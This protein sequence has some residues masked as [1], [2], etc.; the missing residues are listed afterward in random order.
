MTVLEKFYPE[1]RKQDGNYYTTA[2]LTAI[3]FSLQRFF[4]NQ[5]IGIIKGPE[6]RESNATFQATLVKLKREGM[7]KTQHKPPINKD[8]NKLYQSGLFDSNSPDTLQNRVFF[9]VMLYFCRRGRQNLR[10]LK[11]D[12]S[13]KTDPSKRKY[14]CKVKDELTKNRRETDEAQ[15]T[16]DMF[17]TGGLLCPV[18]SFEQYVSHLNPKNEFFFQRLKRLKD[19]S[20]D[21]WY[22]NMVVGQGT[23]GE[24]MKKLST[25]AE[26]SYIYTNHSIRATAIT[27]LDECG[28]EAR[29]IMAVSGHKSENSIRSYA[30][31]TSLSKKRKM[32]EAL[33]FSTS[34]NKII[35]DSQS[36]S[37][38]ES[39]KSLATTL[40][41][42]RK[43]VDTDRFPRTLF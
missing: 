24:K 36:F 7:A 26:L 35:S 1:A 29:H 31:R 43:V 28:Y 2:S 15:E 19:V 9:E 33:S 14:V 23:L 39:S 38:G 11:S 25:D 4:S 3:R 5:S 10:N 17:A 12:F 34:E 22:D 8:I 27:V 13:I 30:A 21:V 6:F 41:T 16:Q 32:S 42:R 40:L 37:I 20:D 18:L